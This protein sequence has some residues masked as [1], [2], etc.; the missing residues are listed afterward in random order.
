MDSASS[1]RIDQLGEIDS[2]NQLGEIDSLNQLGE[3]DSL[4]E[5]PA[6]RDQLWEIDP[7]KEIDPT[8]RTNSRMEK[9]PRFTSLILDKRIDS[10]YLA[11]VPAILYGTLPYFG[12]LDVGSCFSV[13]FFQAEEYQFG[14]IVLYNQLCNCTSSSFY[15]PVTMFQY[16]TERALMD[17]LWS[18]YY[19]VY[20][21][22]SEASQREIQIRNWKT[23]T[24]L[25]IIIKRQHEQIRLC[26][27]YINEHLNCTP[28]FSTDALSFI[29]Y[30][31]FFYRRFV[32]SVLETNNYIYEC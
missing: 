31:Q 20:N 1:N 17:K 3:I 8:N 12:T 26:L 7:L 28:T 5:I 24:T 29:D 11:Y 4:L 30:C 21:E 10:Y 13:N 25:T 32:S 2:L 16:I 18:C 22:T 9:D 23:A 27:I 14:V 19:G 6:L 15:I